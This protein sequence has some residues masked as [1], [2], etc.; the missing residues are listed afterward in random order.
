M[1][2]DKALVVAAKIA[3]DQIDFAM[4]RIIDHAHDLLEVGAWMNGHDHP[5][6]TKDRNTLF[7]A[8]AYGV[9]RDFPPPRAKQSQM[10]AMFELTCRHIKAVLGRDLGPWHNDPARTKQEVLDLLAWALTRLEPAFE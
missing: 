8:I 9:T 5:K 3:P 1:N 7:S 10:Q 6:H 2:A 4:A